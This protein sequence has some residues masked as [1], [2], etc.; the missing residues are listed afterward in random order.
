M[1]NWWTHSIKVIFN[2]NT[3]E[4]LFGIPNDEHDPIMKQFNFV[5]L[6]ARYYIYKSKKA[7]AKLDLYISLLECKNYIALEKSIMA[8][9]NE[10]KK[11]KKNWQELY[12]NL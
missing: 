7:G 2:L 12:K 1:L 8:A 9:N 3:Y 10:N 4:I 6:M 11:F 5:L